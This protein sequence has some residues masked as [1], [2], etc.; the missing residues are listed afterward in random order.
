MTGVPITLDITLDTG[1]LLGLERRNERAQG[2]VR[3]AS[4]TG[5]RIS[6]PAGVLAQAWRASRRQHALAVLLGQDNVIVVPLDTRSAL[7][8]GAVL[9]ATGTSDV[10]DASVV[11]TARELGSVVVTSDPGDIATLDPDLEIVTI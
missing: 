9:A 8:C 1:A 6:I 2:L 10:V 3:R 5:A 11:V 7:A 4:R